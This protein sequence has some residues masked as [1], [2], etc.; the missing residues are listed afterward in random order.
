M[1]P[2]QFVVNL[3]QKNLYRNTNHTV[4]VHNYMYV[5]VYMHVYVYVTWSCW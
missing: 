4:S 1:L 2:H 3:P 5:H